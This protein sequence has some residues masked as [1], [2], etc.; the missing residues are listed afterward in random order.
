MPIVYTDSTIV[1]SSPSSGRRKTE[2]YHVVKVV[3]LFK[4]CSSTQL[5]RSTKFKRMVDKGLE[6]KSLFLSDNTQ[7]HQLYIDLV[8]SNVIS[9]EVLHLRVFKAVIL[10]VSI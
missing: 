10:E 1:T 9:S 2:Q 3:M 5:P 6:E 4:F 8:K 7:Y